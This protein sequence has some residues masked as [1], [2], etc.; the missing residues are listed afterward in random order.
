MV[1]E[2]KLDRKE[3]TPIR[4]SFDSF[5]TNRGSILCDTRTPLKTKEYMC[6]NCGKIAAADVLW[7]LK[8]D[9]QKPFCGVCKK[10]VVLSS[11]E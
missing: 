5:G 8:N 2:K 7:K 10:P 3:E 6:P 1:N 4:Q 11:T 9:A